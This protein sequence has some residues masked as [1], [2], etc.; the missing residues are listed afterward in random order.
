MADV[1]AHTATT[2]VWPARVVAGRPERAWI[3]SPYL[4]LFLLLLT[5]Y[6][7]TFPRWADWNQNS[8]FNL[9]RAIVEQRTLRIDAYVANTGDYALID[10][11]AYTD[12]APG[13]SLM[14]VPVHALAQVVRPFGPGWLAERLGANEAFAQTLNPD[15]A[16]TSAERVYIAAS[17]YLAVLACVALPAALMGVM[18]ARMVERA[19]G[20]RTAGVLAAAIVGLATPVFTYSQAF[21]GH[22]PAAA[23]LVGA[24]AAL[25]LSEARPSDRRLLL[26]GFLLG[27]AVLI[28]YP[29]AV[30]GFPIAL[31]A[32]YL[33][34]RRA[35]LL[36]V[37]GALG[38]LAVLALYDMLAFGTPLPVGYEHSALWQ[39]Q[40]QQGFLSL[41]RPTVDALWGLTGGSFRGLFFIAP[42]LLLALPGCILGLAQRETR[43]VTLVVAAAFA[44]MLLFAASSVMWWGGFAVGPR[45]ILP[46]VPLLTLPLGFV[47]ARINRAARPWRAVGF[48]GVGVLSVVSGTLT[49]GLTFARQNYPPDTITDPVR[50]YVVP[51]LRDGD[52]ARNVGMAAHLTGPT[53]LL[54][55]LLLLAG[56]GALLL[57]TLIE[58]QRKRATA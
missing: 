52:V 43:G 36:G 3:R 44:G 19:S 30:A 11:H 50:D 7:Y 10:G 39:E 25:V 13:M 8:R 31:Y 21:Y 49:W 56:V 16:G 17:L 40:H 24:L 14:A 48:V 34:G 42:V 54:P 12:K 2:R 53:S 29:S 5:A 45:Y 23:C 9:T 35:V 32:L 46:A 22:I 55:L 57:R 28:E 26:V 20:C 15:G 27:L 58:A 38:P 37:A 6:G 18:L 47:L 33:A 1:T 51:A 41:T 4:L